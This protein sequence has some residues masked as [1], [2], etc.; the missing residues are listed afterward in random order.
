[1]TSDEPDIERLFAPIAPAAAPGVILRE[2]HEILPH[3]RKPIE[4]ELWGSDMIGALSRSAGGQQ[5]AMA[6]LAAGLVPAA[7]EAGTPQALALLRVLAALGDRGLRQRATQA[8]ERAVA[9]GIAGPAWSPG[10]G[11]PAAGDC[12]HYGDVSGQQESLTVTFR[13]GQDSHALSVLIDHASGGKIRDMWAGDA[14]GLLDKTW[15][16]AG[17]DP[18]VVFESMT[19]GAA[20]AR[21]RQAI[22]AGECPGKP[23]ERDDVTAHRALLH[24]RVR[25]LASG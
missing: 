10:L 17:N 24:A 21:L 1:M 7:A 16:A 5:Q 11:A 13:Y 23:D 18:L 8:A 15:I 6:A 4:A 22:E 12:W 19:P 2:A 20:G 3:V 14:E 9:A 25:L